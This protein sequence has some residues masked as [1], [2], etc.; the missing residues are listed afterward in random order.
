MSTHCN[1]S[2]ISEEALTVNV[3]IAKLELFR[4]VRV[5][6]TPSL[7]STASK[8]N[9]LLLSLLEIITE[10]GDIPRNAVMLIFKQLLLLL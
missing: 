6:T 8:I 4:K 9:S 5:F 1:T 7:E 10:V 3:N 2:W